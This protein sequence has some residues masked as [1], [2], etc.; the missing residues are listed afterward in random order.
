[1]NDDPLHNL[2]HSAAHLLA[3]AVKQL[4][5]GAK[6]AIGPAIAD[7]FYQDFDMGDVKLTD[8]DLVT[9]E[10]T[11]QEILKTW[12]PFVVSEVSLEQAKQDF[13]DNPYKLELIADLAAEH[14]TITENNPGNFLDLCKGGHS[15]NPQV[16]LQH[17]KLLSLAG[18][19]WRGDQTKKMLTRIYGTAFATD[20]ELQQ[21]L[22]MLAEAKQRDHRKLGKEL[23]LFTIVDEVGPGFPLFYPK[24]AALRKAVEDF[25]HGEQTKLGFQAIWVPHLAKDLLYK[26]SGHLGKYDAMFP[27]MQLDGQ[28]YHLKPMNCPHFMMLYKSQPHSYR[29]LPLRWTATT[30]VYRN[31]KSGELGGLTR[32]RALTQ[33]D[34]H[35]FMRPDQIEVELD[36]VLNLIQRIYA[37]FGLSDFWVSISTR[38]PKQPDKYLGDAVIWDKAEQILKDIITK[39]QWACQVVPGEAAF[40]GPKLDFMVKDAIGREWQ[41]STVQLDFNLPER[42]DLEFTAADGSK[43]RP[44][45]AHR[46]VLGSVERWL[47]IMIEHFA[48]KFPVWLAPVQMKILSVSEAHVEYCKK[49]LA[50]WQAQGLRVELDDANETIGHKVRK[51]SKE[52]IPYVVVIGDKEIASGEAA[53]RKRGSKE[54]VTLPLSN[55]MTLVHTKVQTRA[56]EL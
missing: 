28:A 4:W 34:C 37:A 54:S 11:M 21:H 31:E 23:G 52:Y 1:M 7:G 14:K 25:V 13:A 6:N 51:A 53:V 2:R 24:G 30:T 27:P 55:L 5:P 38:D 41:L 12:Q 18:A 43:Q 26:T 40:Y 8:D 3:A 29:D 15:A 45:V 46:A 10:R 56:L 22:T 44:V 19:Y 47:G 9:I 39:R 36:N 33:D 50:D 17:V 42:F 32:V 35:I 20:Q 16:E 49:L 48:G